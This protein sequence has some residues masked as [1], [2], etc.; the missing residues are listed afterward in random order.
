MANA[1]GTKRQRLTNDEAQD[2]HPDWMSKRQFAV[3]VVFVSDRETGRRNLW[4]MDVS[5]GEPIMLTEKRPNGEYGHPCW[6]NDGA[7]IAFTFN[8]EIWIVS[9][10][11]EDVVGRAVSSKGKLTAT[12][13]KLK[14]IGGA[15]I[16]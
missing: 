3:Q 4:L 9:Q 6:S 8:N 10:L 2:L 15:V 12:W 16:P 13:G 14:N 11:P 5:G 1:D 7:K